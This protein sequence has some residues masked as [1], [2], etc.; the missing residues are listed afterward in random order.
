MGMHGLRGRMGYGDTRAMGTSAA[1]KHGLDRVRQ[2]EGPVGTH[3]LWGHMG[4]REHGLW[5]H[6]LRG[7]TG[8]IV[9]VSMRGLLLLRGVC[10]CCPHG[11]CLCG[12]RLLCDTSTV[13][14]SI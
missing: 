4:C 7:H 2:G 14:L 10:S 1:G 6:T 3:G 9:S 13:Q 5:G 8:W 11:S 12:Y